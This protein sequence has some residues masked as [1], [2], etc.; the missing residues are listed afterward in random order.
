MLQFAHNVEFD[1]QA[2]Y[3]R[4]PNSKSL[5]LDEELHCT[6]CPTRYVLSEDIASNSITLH[7]GYEMK[8]RVLPYWL[9][10]LLT[11]FGIKPDIRMDFMLSV[12]YDESGFNEYSRED[13]DKLYVSALFENAGLLAS[14]LLKPIVW[15]VVGSQNEWNW[16][17]C[18]NEF[19]YGH[20]EPYINYK[21]A[22]DEQEG[23]QEMYGDVSD[24]DIFIDDDDED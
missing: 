1:E 16:R 4:K 24:E 23:I 9:L 11:L 6:V 3:G 20:V 17:G 18:S 15:I 8:R 21:Y 13:M 19:R 5:I 10:F 2:A 14:L 7:A 12:M 22:E